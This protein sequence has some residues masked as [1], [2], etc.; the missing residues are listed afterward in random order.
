MDKNIFKD[1]LIKLNITLN[2]NQ[3]KKLDR[4]YQLLIEWNEKMNLTGITEEKQ[5]Y[6]KHFYDSLTILRIIDLNNINTLCDI[7]SGAGFPGL[8]LKIVYPN[9][10]IV[11]IDSLLKRVKFLNFVI[12]DLGLTNIEAIHIRAEDY[13]KEKKEKFDLVTSRAVA[14]LDILTKISMPLVKKDGSFVAMKGICDDE[15]SNSIKTIE[16]CHGKIVK[17]DKFLLPIENSNR[18]LIKITKES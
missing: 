4:Y 14:K 1:E 15:I 12:N 13:I 16:D 2:D 6:L 17:T 18:C 10:K 11:L 7:G 5:V 8:V 3:L 9:I